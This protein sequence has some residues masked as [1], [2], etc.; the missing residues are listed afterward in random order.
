[1]QNDG[2]HLAQV[3]IARLKEPLDSPLLEDFVA[4]LAPINAIADASEGFVWRLQTDDGD[5]TSIR[6]FDDDQLIVN[7]STWESFEALGDYVYRS[8]HTGVMRQRRR[9]FEQMREMYMALWWVPAGHRPSVAEAEE[10]L[11]HL[12]THGPTPR[13]FTF[14]APFSPPGMPATIEARVG[15]L[16]RA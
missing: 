8:G 2:F 3:N 12:Q 11:Q 13:A 6:A 4:A 1:M 9:W 14:R 5:A 15:D 7:M 16:C 10:R